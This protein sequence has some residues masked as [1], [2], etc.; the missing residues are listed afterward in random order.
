[1]LDNSRGRA[2][3]ISD[4]VRA[5]RVRVVRDCG[6]VGVD[7]DETATERLVEVVQ[8]IWSRGEGE[9][10]AE[11]NVSHDHRLDG[12]DGWSGRKTYRKPPG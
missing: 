4:W 1:V 2:G 3:T 11:M 7:G 5:E 8:R 10:V 9:V 6:L 12:G